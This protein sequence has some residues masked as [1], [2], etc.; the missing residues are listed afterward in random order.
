MTKLS[1]LDR[2]SIINAPIGE[3]LDRKVNLKMS[4]RLKRSKERDMNYKIEEKIPVPEGRSK[5][6]FKKM[7]V[8]DSFTCKD[9]IDFEKAR[10]Y[11]YTYACRTGTKF[12]TRRDDFRIWRTS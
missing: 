8:G 1:V 6:P 5:Y 12:N 2:I 10:S 9:R 3:P 4:K 7:N 11:A